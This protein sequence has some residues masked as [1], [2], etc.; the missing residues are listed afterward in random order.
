MKPFKLNLLSSIILVAASSLLM[1][2][3]SAS[4]ESWPFANS[5]SQ[6]KQTEFSQYYYVAQGED[7]NNIIYNARISANENVRIIVNYNGHQIYSTHLSGPGNI[8]FPIPNSTSGFHRL[9]FIAQSDYNNVSNDQNLC[10]IDTPN[11]TISLEQANINYQAVRQNFLLKNLPDAL[12][13]PK[14][15][16][17]TPLK[18]ALTFNQTSITE[19]SMLSR[20][21]SSWE[22][23]RPLQWITPNNTKAEE[24]NFGV[25]IKQNSQIKAA[26]LELITQ[27]N[28]PTL[29]IEY[30]TPKDLGNAINALLSP[31]YLQQLD[32]QTAEISNTAITPQWA[33]VKPFNNL[34]D[35][36][37][38]N[39][40]LGEGKQSLTLHFP[41]T[42]QPTD[43]LQGQIALRSQSGLLEGSV[44]TAWI[45]EA[46]A[47]SMKLANLESDPVD[48]QFNIFGAD[49]ATSPVFNLTIENTMIANSKCIPRAQGSIWINTEKSNITLP[50]KQKLGV[51]S[52]STVLSTNPNIAVNEDI[53][54]SSMAATV[55]QTAKNMLMTS[56]PVPLTLHK[57]DPTHP[58]R[59]NIRVNPD[60]YNQ[61]VLMH[62]DII[63]APTA[64]HGFFVIYQNERFNIITDNHLGAEAFNNFWP[65]IQNQI[66]SDVANI[67]VSTDG[68]IYILKKTQ[69]SDSVE[70][71]LIK[72][73]N[74]SIIL[75][76]VAFIAILLLI[77]AV[78]WNWR[79]R[80]NESKNE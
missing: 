66:P 71:P 53:D 49:I 4:T 27:N 26:K 57:F 73:S 74:T 52:L 22:T 17:T 76:A 64:A 32:T 56:A 65:K 69:V 1:Q 48:R 79:K 39:F 13:N 54:S 77:V 23:S 55:M 20:L 10:L 78:I 3:T 28:V 80:K 34:A 47:G 31:Q 8:S 45:N 21:F 11:Q 37:I 5:S 12:Y 50:Y 33:I 58:Q 70:H 46:L 51:I 29:Q 60:I 7:W 16:S 43:I 44:I 25:I 14:F 38:Q 9:D 40:R 42:W 6:N 24:I 67:F 68:K 2:T 63:Y 75:I 62:K 30:R 15:S 19:K 18:V 41:A 61:Q 72:Q 35:F 36:G 59:V